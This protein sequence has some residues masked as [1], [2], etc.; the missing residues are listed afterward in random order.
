[1]TVPEDTASAPRSPH[2][3]ASA[4]LAPRAAPAGRLRGRTRSLMLF[5]SA[6]LLLTGL[7]SAF[8]AEAQEARRRWERMCQL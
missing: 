2:L 7:F 5:M 6:A 1:M 8:P 3:P 4:G